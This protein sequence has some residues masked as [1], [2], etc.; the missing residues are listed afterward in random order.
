MPH[1]VPHLLVRFEVFVEW[2]VPTLGVKG[3]HA[4]GLE[5]LY[6]SEALGLSAIWERLGNFQEASSGLDV[7]NN[8]GHGWTSKP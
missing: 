1:E 4:S 2:G 6:T 5:F 7:V 3:P 8:K